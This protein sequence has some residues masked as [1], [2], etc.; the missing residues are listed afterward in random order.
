MWKRRYI[1]TKSWYERD[2][3]SKWRWVSPE[4]H[5]GWRE[6]RHTTFFSLEAFL[7]CHSTKP[8]D[9]SGPYFIFSPTGI[10]SIFQLTKWNQWNTLLYIKVGLSLAAD[11]PPPQYVR[12]WLSS[13]IQL[14][15][16]SKKPNLFRAIKHMTL[17]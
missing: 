16:H 13:N 12:L 17:Q 9:I 7:F 3:S 10:V 5:E 11:S 1:K 8:V 2:S 4:W 6:D 14:L 15:L